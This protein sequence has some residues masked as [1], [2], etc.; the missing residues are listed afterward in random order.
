[1]EQIV[2]VIKKKQELEDLG[3]LERNQL[4]EDLIRKE[5]CPQCKNYYII[6]KKTC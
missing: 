1:M 5:Q 4:M 6:R 3:H 2:T